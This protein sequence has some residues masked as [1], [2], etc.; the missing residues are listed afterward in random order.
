MVQTDELTEPAGGLVGGKATGAARKGQTTGRRSR[1]I[2][3]AVF[4]APA[5]ITYVVFIFYPLV[6]T[7]VW[8]F[9]SWA[10]TRRVAFSGFDNYT[11]IF[12]QFPFNT[13]VGNAALHNLVFFLYT[14]VL[15]NGVGLLLAV[16]LRR[17]RRTRV[18]LQ[19]SYTL[20]Y[21]ISPLVIGYLWILLLNP[22]FGPV[23]GLLDALNLGQFYQPWLGTEGTALAAASV[24][25]AWQSMGLPMLLFSAALAGI[26]EEL[27]EAAR[28][29][30]ANAWQ[31]FKSITLP[32]VTPAIT[33]VTLLTFIWS[34]NVFDLMYAVGGPNGSPGGATD[35]LGLLF[36]RV[37]FTGGSNG[38]GTAGA[39][40]TMLFGLM[41]VSVLALTRLRKRIE[42]A[43]D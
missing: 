13:Q 32:L 24:V 8:S 30:G 16:L 18:G 22:I 31:C 6:T 26:P 37:A 29:D 23:K 5:L 2:W 41:L 15:Q 38:L 36:Y 12:T 1:L 7:I 28:C 4:V 21:M 33:T 17:T 39:L 27:Y 43:L 25:N 9:S 14:M 10:G 34:F 35:V 42:G 11:Y 19:A 20:P 40:A 3:G